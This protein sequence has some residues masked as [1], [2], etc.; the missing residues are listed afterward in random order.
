MS[1]IASALTSHQR[2]RKNYNPIFDYDG[3]AAFLVLTGNLAAAQDPSKSVLESVERAVSTTQ[4]EA[5]LN[6][7]LGKHLLHPIPSVYFGVDR[8]QDAAQRGTKGPSTGRA[9]RARAQS[10]GNRKT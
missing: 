8:Y 3:Q 1:R 7:I 2:Q 9:F 4:Q 10:S 5:D 6:P